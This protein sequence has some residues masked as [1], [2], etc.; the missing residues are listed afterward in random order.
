MNLRKD[1]YRWHFFFAVLCAPYCAR[2]SRGDGRRGV[3][4]VRGRM[5][6][7]CG[8]TSKSGSTFSP[9]APLL[10]FF[11]FFNTFLSA[12]VLVVETEQLLTVDPSARASM[13]NAANCDT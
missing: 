3:G 6:R 13:K 9:R 7:S 1:H 4:Q 5:F 2:P 10:L 12:W 11:F 8:W